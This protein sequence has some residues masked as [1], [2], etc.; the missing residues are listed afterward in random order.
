[1]TDSTIIILILS[2]ALGGAVIG[3]ALFYVAGRA[4]LSRKMSRRVELS[5]FSEEE[6]E[7]LMKKKGFRI[8]GK[9]KRADIITYIDGKP[10]LGFVQADLIVEKGGK[11]YVAEVKAGELVSD[12][13]E[14]STR[15]QLLEYKFAY[16]PYGI[17]LVDMLDGTIHHIDFEHPSYGE[18]KIFRL[19]LTALVVI[20]VLGIIWVFASIKIL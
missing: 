3:S 15:R 14:P 12:P 10:N 2:S 16:K 4:L 19:I 17:L 13:T 18:D 1:M 5:R 7:A 9:Q 20:I 11:K 6:A 8:I